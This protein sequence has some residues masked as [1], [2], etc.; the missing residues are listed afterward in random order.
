SGNG[1]AETQNDQVPSVWVLDAPSGFQTQGPAGPGESGKWKELLTGEGGCT[2]SA[3]GNVAA[4][5]GEDMRSASVE[6]LPSVADAAD[7][8]AGGARGRRL[9]AGGAGPGQGPTTQPSVVRPR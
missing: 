6:L 7:A 9:A 2:L 8:P 5:P 3:R 4:K 1:L